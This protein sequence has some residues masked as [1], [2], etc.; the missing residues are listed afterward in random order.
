MKHQT[1]TVAALLIAT[2]SISSLASIKEKN[3]DFE[4]SPVQSNKSAAKTNKAVNQERG[5]LLYEN[6]CTQCHGSM[7]HQRSNRKAHSIKDIR[8]WVLRWSQHLNLNWGSSDV[9]IV[10]QYINRRFYHYPVEQ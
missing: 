6:H 8:Q 4:T 5:R 1:Y 2:I 3:T 10:T 7:A 9:D